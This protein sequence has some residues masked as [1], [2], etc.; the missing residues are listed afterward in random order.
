MT[1]GPSGDTN[2]LGDKVKA[3]LAHFRE[4]LRLDPDS[5]SALT[6]YADGLVM[7]GDE[8]CADEATRLYEQAAQCQPADAME[9]LGVEMARHQL[10]GRSS[11][12]LLTY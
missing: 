1:G 9:C 6:G 12:Y 3:A 11:S 5:P 7:L 8:A 2:G 10:R 4:A